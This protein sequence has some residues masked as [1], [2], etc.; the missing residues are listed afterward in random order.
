MSVFLRVWRGELSLV[1][2]FWLA[3]LLPCV[4]YLLLIRALMPT[5]AATHPA[6]LASSWAP[7]LV[8]AGLFLLMF[9]SL[10]G[11]WRAAGGYELWPRMLAR[12]WVVLVVGMAYVI[13]VVPWLLGFFA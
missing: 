7:L 11:L 13:F 3:H 5:L 4:G 10:T 1:Q 12:S 9:W 8:G 2:H 6:L